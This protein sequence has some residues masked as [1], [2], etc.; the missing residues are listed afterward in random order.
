MRRF[1][2]SLEY[3]GTS[4]HGWQRQ[5]D[6]IS[7]QQVL[8]EAIYKFS[9]EKASVFAAGRTDAGVHARQQ[10]CHIDLATKLGV[11][12][13]HEAINAFLL[14]WPVSVLAVEE[15]SQEFHARF[16]AKWRRYEYSIFNRRAKPALGAELVWHVTEPL[17]LEAMQQ[18]AQIFIG[19]HDFSSFRAKECQAKSPIKTLDYFDLTQQEHRITANIQ[20]RSFLH[21]QV[22]NMMGSLVKVGKGK[23]TKEDLQK[24]LE[25]KNRCA[26]GITAPSS[27]LFLVE[28]GY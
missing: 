12:R 20:A 13:I 17:N 3:Q 21:H 10:V 7:V 2:I 1:K 23:W 16:S 14:C 15:V 5:N 8:E 27:G 11:F 26:A 18:A 25:A 4:F 9:G 19:Q 22:R 28:V 24:A 6:C